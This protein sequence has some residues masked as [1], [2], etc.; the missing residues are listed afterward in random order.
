MTLGGTHRGGC[1]P[2]S[3]RTAD[4]ISARRV[5][6]CPARPGSQVRLP[7][8]AVLA[9]EEKHVRSLF[10]RVEAVEEVAGTL[11]GD[12]ERS[13]GAGRVLRPLPPEAAG[14]R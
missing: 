4:T 6:Q 8:V 14:S 10:E 5:C 3:A 9:V 11:A 1:S 7:V 12:D 2:G 13:R